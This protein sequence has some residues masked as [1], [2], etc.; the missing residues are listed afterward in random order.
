MTITP[1]PM[2]VESLMRVAARRTMEATVQRGATIFLNEPA[3]LR[4]VIPNVAEY[5]AIEL[6]E[7]LEHRIVALEEALRS[8]S[9]MYDLNGHL[10][11]K[12]AR[13]A[14]NDPA[15]DKIWENYRSE[16]SEFKSA[17]DRLNLAK[18]GQRK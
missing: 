15:F 3:R 11:L 14:A 13:C 2:S 18:R 8:G 10:A 4:F 5:T 7:L 9:W 1:L 17:I 12:Q 16:I 6:R